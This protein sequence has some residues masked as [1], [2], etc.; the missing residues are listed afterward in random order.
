MHPQSEPKEI[1]DWPQ[2]PLRTRRCRHI[3]TAGRQCGS[4]CLR[5]EQFCYFHHTTRRPISDPKLRRA[6]TSTY[7]LPVPED[8]DSIRAGIAQ[9][10]HD[11]ANN[12]IDPRRAGLI[13]YSLQIALSALPKELAMP[14]QSVSIS[15]AARPATRRASHRKS[16]LVNEIAA[17]PL[18]E[19]TVLDDTYG[20]I[21]PEAFLE[22]EAEEVD[23]ECDPGDEV[24]ENGRLLR[25]SLGY[26]LLKVVEVYE[27]Q[28]E[29]YEKARADLLKHGELSAP[30]PKSSVDI[31]ASVGPFLRPS[32]KFMVYTQNSHEPSPA[33]PV[34]TPRA[35]KL[36]AGSGLRRDVRGRKR[37]A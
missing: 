18:I 19:E 14:I 22:P 2:Q 10:M 3:F 34:R 36:S 32:E 7:D 17:E 37:T 28:Q 5:T 21:A 24:P 26:S 16:L 11:I 13:L 12:H 9:V 30:Q 15:A 1:P 6:R 33:E 29:G 31:D 23:E 27:A 25:N 35:Q 20:L 8:R 4:P